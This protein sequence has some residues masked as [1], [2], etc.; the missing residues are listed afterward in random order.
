MKP[1]EILIISIGIFMTIIAWVVIEIYKVNNSQLVQETIQ[2]PTVKK[3][4]VD[5]T[6]IDKLRNKKP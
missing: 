1:R 2:L 4:E 6:V 5:L 3:Y